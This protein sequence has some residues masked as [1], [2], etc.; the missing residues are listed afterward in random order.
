M[1]TNIKGA[2]EGEK[3][4]RKRESLV[5]ASRGACEKWKRLKV[6]QQ[7]QPAS[8]ESGEEGAHGCGLRARTRAN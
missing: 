2:E 1:R 5:A 6:G 7:Q 3:R 4:R 8:S